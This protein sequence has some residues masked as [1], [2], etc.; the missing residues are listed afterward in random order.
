MNIIFRGCL[1]E[2]LLKIESIRVYLCHIPSISQIYTQNKKPHSLRRENEVFTSGPT[3]IRTSNQ[4][5]MSTQFLESAFLF[6]A[7][8]NMYLCPSLSTCVHQKRIP[9]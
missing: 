1:A 9:R 5:I 7:E 2:K 6:T 3:E 8:I 4:R